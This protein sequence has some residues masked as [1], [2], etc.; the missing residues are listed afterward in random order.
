MSRPI[1]EGGGL[2]DL[3][4]HKKAELYELARS[5]GLPRRSRMTKA[6]LIDALRKRT[7]AAPPAPEDC[8]VRERVRSALAHADDL[9]ASDLTVRAAD[10]TVTLSGSVPNPCSRRTAQEVA[11]SV[12]GVREVRNALRVVEVIG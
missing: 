1:R 4:Q 7:A 11:S 2:G 8:R 9:E 3:A 10:G 5:L 6:E 12:D